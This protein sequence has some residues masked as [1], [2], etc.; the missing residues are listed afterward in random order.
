MGFPGQLYGAVGSDR[1]WKLESVRPHRIFG[2][3]IHTNIERHH[4][5]T[6]HGVQAELA[7]LDQ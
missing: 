4:G 6:A 1:R 2:G 5:D 3:G 7:V